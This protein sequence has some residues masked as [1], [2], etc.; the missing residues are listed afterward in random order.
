[1]SEQ[2]ELNKDP[3]VIRCRF[4]G[5]KIEL[6]DDSLESRAAGR[7]PHQQM[8]RHLSKHLSEAYNH[9]RRGTI[10]WLIDSLAFTPVAQKERWAAH[11][12][13]LLDQAMEG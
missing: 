6:R 11:V 8:R 7:D 9:V 10:P 12:R 13:A 3:I 2:N 1:M 5:Q 4:C